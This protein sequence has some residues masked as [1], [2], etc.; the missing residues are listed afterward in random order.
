MPN[1]IFA[2]LAS[3]IFAAT[4]LAGARVYVYLSGTTTQV[5][6]TNAA[7]DALAQPLT[8]GSDG[9][10]ET[11]YV[12]GTDLVTIYVTDSTGAALPGYP[13]DNVPPASLGGLIA[14]SVA[15]T[16][17]EGVAATNV[18]SAIELVAA[19]ALA[20]S[21]TLTR[22]NTMWATGGTAD[23]YTITPDPAITAYETG[24]AF[25]VLPNRANTA[26]ATLNVNGL[27]IR[28][29]RRL[30]S[31]SVSTALTAGEIQPGKPFL[32]VYDGT[33][34][35]I[36][37]DRSYVGGSS[38]S[39]RIW[40][41]SQTGFQVCWGVPIDIASLTAGSIS[42]T[43]WTFPAAFSEVAFV[44]TQAY[45]NRADEDQADALQYLTASGSVLSGNATAVIR[46][47]NNSGST[48]N[49]VRVAAIAVGRF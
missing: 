44:G 20:P 22:A 10:F 23:A 45:T 28:D 3:R 7:G 12:A 43:T 26:A 5:A 13:I 9:G 46:V 41:H 8:T 36:Q 1:P 25:R 15:Y 37:D 47:R 27:G 11:P 16:P 6:L 31:S 2:P 21:A 40:R 33:R 19:L 18:Q 14:A 49:N 29:I 4:P 17:S 34:F 24:L 39:N 35:I 48:I 30:N 38:F 42:R 32:A